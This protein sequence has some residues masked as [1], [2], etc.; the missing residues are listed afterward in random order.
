MADLLIY[1]S[2]DNSFPSVV[3]EAAALSTP[4]LVAEG[5]ASEYISNNVNG[6]FAEANPEAMAGRIKEI[7]E[8]GNLEEVGDVAKNTLPTSWDEIVRE[9]NM[10]YKKAARELQ[11]RRK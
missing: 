4:S 3:R 1:P 8:S 6:Y 10:R 7:F 11:K 9:S 5:C 2:P